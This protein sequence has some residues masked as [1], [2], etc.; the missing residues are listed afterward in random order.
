LEAKG[1]VNAGATVIEM[2]PQ[3]FCQNFEQFEGFLDGLL[4]LK[5]MG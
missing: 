2:Y 4:S 1:W 5:E 3:M